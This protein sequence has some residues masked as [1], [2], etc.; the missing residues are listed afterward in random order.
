MHQPMKENYKLLFQLG[1]KT[2]LDGGQM[3]KLMMIP[4]FREFNSW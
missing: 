1:L 4:L 3:D 2:M